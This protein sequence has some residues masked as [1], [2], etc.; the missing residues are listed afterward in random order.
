MP[1]ELLTDL[2]KTIQ[3]EEAKNDWKGE[4]A[5]W[6]QALIDT[7]SVTQRELDDIEEELFTYQDDDDNFSEEEKQLVLDLTRRRAKTS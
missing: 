2:P 1:G 7:V 3:P 6:I 4:K 5:R